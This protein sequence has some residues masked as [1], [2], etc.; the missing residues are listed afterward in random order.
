MRSELDRALDSI[1][2]EIA[3]LGDFREPVAEDFRCAIASLGVQAEY[4]KQDIN[5]V[6]D[7]AAKGDSDALTDMVDST[8]AMLAHTFAGA[9]LARLGGKR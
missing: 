4:A 7:D 9:M 3:N 8:A 5:R 1:A 2:D 6:I